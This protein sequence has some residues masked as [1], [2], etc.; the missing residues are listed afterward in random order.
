LSIRHKTANV[1]GL[2]CRDGFVIFPRLLEPPRAGLA[3]TLGADMSWLDKIKAL[4]SLGGTARQGGKLYIVDAGRGQD[5]RHPREQ[6]YSL[7]RMGRFAQKENIR[8]QAVFE[9]R[10]LRE[11]QNGGEYQGVTVYFTDRADAVPGKILDLVRDGQRRHAVTVITGDN[12]LEAKVGAAG[13]ACLRPSTFRRVIEDGRSGG[14]REDYSQGQNRGGRNR[15]RRR[16]GRGGRGG[17]GG[18]G[19]GPSPQ[20][21]QP[22]NAPQ[23]AEQPARTETAAP[24]PSGDG[25]DAIRNVI[26][27][28][29]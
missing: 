13:S 5:R 9:G 12:G 29:E 14:E 23:G 26:D 19:R 28:V 27:L 11:V 1:P 6:L 15:R 20:G 18:G 7:Q 17:G 4:F 25:R 8:I 16:G 24:R 3:L 22:T 21:S 2:Q 10:D